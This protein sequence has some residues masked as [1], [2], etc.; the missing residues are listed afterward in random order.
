MGALL[1]RIKSDLKLMGLDVRLPIILRP[2]SKTMWGYY[3]VSKDWIVLYVYSNKSHTRFVHYNIL[4]RTILH[5]YVHV[6]QR[7]ASAW[8]RYE[9]IMHDTEFWKMYNYL[10]S[11]A[12]ER[13][14][15]YGKSKR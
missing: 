8:K 6:L 11:L 2:Y 13:G 12:V 10:T 9:G 1:K 3:D 4:F 7:K 5:E 15:I 14:V